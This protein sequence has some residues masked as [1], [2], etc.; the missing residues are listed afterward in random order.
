MQLTRGDTGKYKFQ[1]L[2]NSGEPIV[3]EPDELHFTV[4]TSYDDENVVFQKS[5][6][7][8]TM[9][10][11]GTWH[12]VIEPEDTQT[13]PVRQYY[14]DIEVIQSGYVCTIAKGVLKLEPE[15]TWS[16]NR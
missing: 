9:D 12:F 10:L 15:A 3:S 4:K 5:K 7:D 14:Y 6:A 11:D 8:M 1:R 2:D 13:L 16:V